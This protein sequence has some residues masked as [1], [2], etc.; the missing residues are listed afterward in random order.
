MDR[1][2][3]PVRVAS[4]SPGGE[5]GRVERPFG[6]LRGVERGAT[7]PRSVKKGTIPRIWRFAASYQ[8]WLIAFLL[9]FSGL[10]MVAF[11]RLLSLA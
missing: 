3:G 5:T 2:R 9:L 11:S 7:A 6:M 1:R 10:A 8:S 4:G